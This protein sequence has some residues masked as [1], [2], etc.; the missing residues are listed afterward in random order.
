MAYTT[1]DDPSAHFHIQLFSGTG[2]SQSIT[3]DANAG[4]FKP[5]WVWIKKRAGGTARNSILTD[6]TRGVT[7][8]LSS[9][10]NDAE[11]TNTNGLTAFGT[12]GF[13]VGSYD[14]VNESSGTYVAWQWKANGATTTTNDASSTSVGNVDSV[15][16]ANTTAGFSIVTFDLTSDSGDKTIAHGLGVAPKLIIFKNRDDAR[17]WAVYHHTQVPPKYLTF[18]TDQV[19]SSDDFNNSTAPT[20]TVFSLETAWHG[21]HKHVAYCFAEI[22][23]YSKF[24]TYTGN[25][26]AEGPFIYTGFKPAWVMI[27]VATGNTGGWPIHDTTRST[28][29]VGGGILPANASSAEYNV[30]SLPLDILSNGF[31]LRQGNAYSDHN[32]TSATYVYI[33]FAESPFV[34]SE[35]VP[36]TAR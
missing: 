36:T 2:S 16:Q 32:A 14:S 28:F 5:D 25:G 12:D 19:A 21:A 33:A 35:G 26:N 34:S 7:K 3:N 4:N 29:N 23:G 30:G 11:F 9:A 13:T 20:S 24:G 18:T 1:I 31:K 27:K 6:S 15:Y 22:Q 10:L 8:C 17:N